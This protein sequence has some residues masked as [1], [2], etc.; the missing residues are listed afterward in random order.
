MQNTGNKYLNFLLKYNIYLVFLLLFII[1][2]VISEDF[3]TLGN[4]VNI[5]QQNAG[6]VIISMGMLLVILTGG[7][8]LSVGSVMALGCVVCA[9]ALKNWG[10]SIPISALLAVIVG[11]CA[12]L[13]TGF[14]IAKAK[15]APFIASLAMMTMAKGIAFMISNGAPII[16]AQKTISKLGTARIFPWLT[17]LTLIAIIVVLIIWF[18]LRY[19][20]YGRIVVAIGSNEEAIHL[21]GIAV[22]PHVISVYAI[23]GMCSALAGVLAASRTGIGTASVGTGMELDCIAACVIGGV[24]LSGGIG[25]PIKTVIGVLSLALIGNIMNLLAVPSYP[26][27]VIRGLI[28]ILAVVL[29]QITSKTK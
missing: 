20:S 8:D 23:S 21:S 15:L 11:G 1:C 25:S 10:L 9:Y 22:K 27:D 17:A 16:T 2:S 13:F 19:T 26:Q 18:V 12:G 3:F 28:I 14:L 5:S 29:Q 7:I 24:S 6:I 4:L